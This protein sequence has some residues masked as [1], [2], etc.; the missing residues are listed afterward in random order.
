M[1]LREVILL[2]RVDEK[3]RKRTSLRYVDSS[4]DHRK[5]IFDAIAHYKKN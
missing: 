3:H 2:G 1:K 5:L 4:D